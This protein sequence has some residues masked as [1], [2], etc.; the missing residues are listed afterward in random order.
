MADKDGKKWGAL[1][2]AALLAKYPNEL[3]PV[4]H[5]LKNLLKFEEKIRRDLREAGKTSKPREETQCYRLSAAPK[6]SYRWE[7][8]PV[9]A[10]ELIFQVSTGRLGHR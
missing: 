6:F 4:V 2:S 5:E 9:L 1:S 7:P 3:L 10:T 8:L